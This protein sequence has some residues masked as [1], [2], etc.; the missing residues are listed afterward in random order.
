MVPATNMC[1]VGWTVKY[2][3]YLMSTHDQDHHSS[4]FVC[5]DDEAEAGGVA[6]GDGA[7]LCVVQGR[8]GALPCELF[9]NGFQL[10]CAVCTK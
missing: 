10:T 5:V 1:P 7:A 6:F 3:G 2:H 8:F 4:Q 9:A